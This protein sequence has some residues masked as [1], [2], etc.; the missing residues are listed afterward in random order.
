LRS[1]YRLHIGHYIIYARYI[2][3]NRKNL[4]CPSVKIVISNIF[5][6][7]PQI[8]TDGKEGYQAIFDD[9]DPEENY[10]QLRLSILAK[11]ASILLACNKQWEG[12]SGYVIQVDTSSIVAKGKNLRI[13]RCET[14]EENCATV[15]EDVST[16]IFVHMF[17]LIKYT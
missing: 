2:I 1:L 16:V 12:K 14:L 8:V 15:H 6:D 4:C 11:S 9:G 3:M 10:T 13:L 17:N 7:L 5:V